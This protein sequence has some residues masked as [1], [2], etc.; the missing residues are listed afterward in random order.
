M[1]PPKNAQLGYS[2]TKHDVN[3]EEHVQKF[4]STTTE[5][6]VDNSTGDIDKSHPLTRSMIHCHTL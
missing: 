6:S 4:L 3:F 5:L 1:G 2:P